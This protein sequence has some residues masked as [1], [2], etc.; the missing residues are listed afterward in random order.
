MR[1][2]ITIN[3]YDY[4]CPTCGGKQLKYLDSV[5]E[6]CGSTITRKNKIYKTWCFPAEEDTACALSRDI[7]KTVEAVEKRPVDLNTYPLSPAQ[8]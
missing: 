2:D 4:E 1:V 5:C 6:M 3:M 8:T 7:T